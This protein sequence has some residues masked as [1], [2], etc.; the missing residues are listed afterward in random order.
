VKKRLMKAAVAPLL[1]PYFPVH[2]HSMYS[3]LDATTEVDDL[4]DKA[5]QLGMRGFMLTDH[6][7]MAGVT[8]LYRACM[9]YGMKPFPGFEG[10]LIDPSSEDPFNNKSERFH[11]GMAAL[12][13]KG[14]QGL[15]KLNSLSHTR[16][17]FSKY[18]RLILSDLKE[19]SDEY[20]PDV[21]LTS[22]CFFGLVQ[23]Q[24]ANGNMEQAERTLKTYA[25]WFPH[26]FVELQHHN[27]DHEEDG[28][29][30]LDDTEMVETLYDL[31]NR[32]G[33]PVVAGQ[34]TH[35]LDQK[36]K[37]AHSLMKKMAYSG[38]RDSA[39]PGDTFHMA[40]AEWVAEHYPPHI[41]EDVEESCRWLLAHNKVRIPALD[42]YKSHVPPMSK[43][44]DRDLSRIV[45]DALSEYLNTMDIGPTRRLNYVR[46]LDEELSVVADV[47]QANYFLLW[48]QFVDW[49]RDERICIEARGSGNGSLIAFLMKITQIDPMKFRTIFERF[50]SRD[51][52]KPPDIDMDV[53]AERRAEC[54]NWW[55]QRFGVV[56]I[57]TWSKLGETN[58]GND[59]GSVLVSYQGFLRRMA[60]QIAYDRF[61]DPT[62]A[63]DAKNRFK[64]D[65]KTGRQYTKK[66]VEEYGRRVFA[67]KF[68]HVQTI[69]A[70]A[71]V[72]RSDYVGLKQLAGMKVLKS[73]GVHPA[74][75]LMNGNDMKIA[76]WIP[77]MLIASKETTVT[78][79]DMDDLDFW[80]LMKNDILGQAVLTVM[81]R[82]Q[83]MI[84]RKDPCDFTWIPE[85]DKDAC[86][87]L[88]EGKVNN[89]IFHFEG[90]TKAKGGKEMGI[91][92]TKDAI[93]A[94]AMYMPGA[95]ESGQKDHYLKYRNA[96]RGAKQKY[97]H[98]YYEQVLSETYGAVL[99]QEQPIEILRKFGMSM[100]NI[101]KLFKVVKDSGKGAAER[102]RVL[103]DELFKEFKYICAR[104]NIEDVNHAW[105]LVT[106]FINYGFNRAHAAGYG[107]RSYRCAYLK[108]HHPLEFMA[109]LLEV[110]TMRGDKD[111]EKAYMREARWQGIRLLPPHVNLSN[112][113]WKVEPGRRPALRK[114]LVS[115][116]GIGEKTA[117]EIASKAPFTSLNDMANRCRIS[118]KNDWL[119]SGELTGVMAKLAAAN[120]LDDLQKTKG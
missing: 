117:V 55:A 61:F 56:Q 118:G 80:G 103:M 53:E 11:F 112:A 23:S 2:A 74:G 30:T 91:R 82:T 28:I 62:T 109:A 102:N 54:L 39:F 106:G 14:Y 81:R 119:K 99:F 51:R 100:E 19:F 50:M 18:P 97:P 3:P 87:I 115:I 65:N 84:G 57:G 98:L 92:S 105:H 26:T 10:Y 60:A 29:A 75:L 76:D 77:T 48:K 78:Q 38:N 1:S 36:H 63:P 116:E 22:G 52:K 47:G 37:T 111:K 58:D 86:K 83:E 114:G 59:R 34:D 33:L 94:S 42:K 31:A 20:G 4:V 113:S 12:T 25:S 44:P 73:G 45:R 67:K 104:E 13:T 70:V 120:A 35:Y 79:F 69:E 107:L 5:H 110:W 72:D 24:V 27:I 66:E 93:I 90:Y 108:A 41:W 21:V 40:S 64:I 46:R 49:C 85:D 15:V 6:G 101:N 16:P 89:G 88:R 7:L 68:G 43:N 96:G 9:K 17:R 95:T 8:K 32:L 71:D